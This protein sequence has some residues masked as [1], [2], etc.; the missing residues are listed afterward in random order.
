[1]CPQ[2]DTNR[3]PF[4]LESDALPTTPRQLAYEKKSNIGNIKNTCN[5]TGI[6]L[7]FLHEFPSLLT[8]IFFFTYRNSLFCIQEFSFLLTGISRIFLY[9]C[10]CFAIFAILPCSKDSLFRLQGFPFLFIEFCI[11]FPFIL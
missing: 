4:T 3:G 5:V 6:P 10:Y 9:I 8:G 7:F 1:M 11:K 2:L